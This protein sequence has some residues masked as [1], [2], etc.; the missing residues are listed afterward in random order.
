MAASTDAP[1]LAH[2]LPALR[3]TVLAPAGARPRPRDLGIDL[4][5]VITA[6]LGLNGAGFDVPR[7]RPDPR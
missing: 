5:E 1:D 2:D 6:L 4:V 3:P 7:G